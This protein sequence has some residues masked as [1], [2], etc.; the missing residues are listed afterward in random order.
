MYETMVYW[1]TADAEPDQERV[2]VDYARQW[3]AAEKVVYSTT[4]GKASSARTRIERSFDPEAVR[5]LTTE[6][7]HDITVDGPHLAA[8]AVR[9]GLIDEYHLIVAPVVAG[10]GTRFF[11]DGLRVE[12]ELLDERR[13][14]NGV[15]FLRYRAGR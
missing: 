15:V 3:Q 8:H 5:R 4:L 2:M 1:E 7:G 10:G 12:L 13:F 11:P 14:A 6:A 9:A